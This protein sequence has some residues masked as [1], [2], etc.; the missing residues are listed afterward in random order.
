MPNNQHL[1]SLLREEIKIMEALS[2]LVRLKKEALLNDDLGQ[3]EQII[4]KEEATS[5]R[6]HK[7]EGACFPQ[8]RFF[9][10]GSKSGAVIPE[11]IVA[12]LRRIKQLATEIQAINEFNRTLLKNSLDLTRFSINFLL[13]AGEGKR[14][15]YGSS[16]TVINNQKMVRFLDSK[17]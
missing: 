10:K 5:A 6:L 8:V 2:Q 12:C 1:E 17:G 9:L 11:E 3:L 13:P 14:D 4:L 7:I 15:L 16:G